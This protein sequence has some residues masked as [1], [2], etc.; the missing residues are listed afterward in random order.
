MKRIL[1][2]IKPTGEIQLGNY[3]GMVK[4]LVEMQNKYEVFLMI[5]DL[6]AQTVSY[7]PKELQELIFDLGA[8]L[9]ALGVNPAKTI[10]FRQSDVPA[11]LYLY[12]IL[13]CLTPIGELQ[14]MHEYKEQ[15][16]RYGR[17]GIGAGVLMYPVLMAADILIYQADLV[18]IGED[19][20]QHLEL[21]R[22][23][24]RKFNNTFGKSFKVPAVALQTETAKIMSLDNPTK[25]MSK[26]QP[27]GNLPIF[28]PESEIKEKIKQAVTDSGSEIIYAPKNKPA[29]SNLM[30]IYKNLSDKPYAKIEQEFK[31][32]GYAQFKTE[33]TNIFLNYFQP[34]RARQKQI[35]P[36]SLDNILRAGA[37]GANL[38]AAKT[39][40]LILKKTGLTAKKWSKN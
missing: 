21:T 28:A 27:A 17:Q 29:I 15:S 6:H 1:T 32:R 30:A 4:D 2:G 5:A 31:G 14:R 25:K 26:S 3:L 37:K 36:K 23:L 11:H 16:E 33:L 18:P 8:S 38:A 39:L 20:V 22:E 7:K 35:S 9:L 34:A 40:K 12:W 24:V 19:Q 13:G 10:L